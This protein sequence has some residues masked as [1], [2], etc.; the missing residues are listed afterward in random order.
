MLKNLYPQKIQKSLGSALVKY[1]N[2][3]GCAFGILIGLS[4]ATPLF[5]LQLDWN[6]QFWFDQT[7]LNN[8]QLDRNVYSDHNDPTLSSNGSQYI[9]GVG[10]RNIVWYAAFLILKPKII[11]NDSIR[12][13][14]EWH[15]GSPTTGFF[16]RSFPSNGSERYTLM[17]SARDN[18]TIGAQRFWASLITD[19]GTIDLGRAPLHWGLGAIWNS[20]D[21][22]FNRYQSTGD[23]IRLTSKFGNFI[24]APMLMKIAS[25]NNAGGASNN[26]G[27]PIAGNDDVTDYG[28]S[29]KYDNSEEDFELGAYWNRRIANAAQSSLYASPANQ[30][31]GSARFDYNMIDFFVRKKLGHYTFGLEIPYVSGKIGSLDGAGDFDYKAFAAILETKYT[32]DIWDIYLKAGH[33]PGQPNSSGGNGSTY[34][35]MH[36]HN[37]YDLGLILYQFNLLGMGNNSLNSQTAGAV[38]SPYDATITNANYLMLRPEVKLDK[39]TLKAAFVAAWADK[40]ATSGE[41][42]FNHETRRFYRASSSQSKFMGFETDFGT[43][44]QWDENILLGLD[45]GLFFPGGYYSF[46]NTGASVPTDLSPM[47]ASQLKVG[48][49]F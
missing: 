11:V 22:L 1:R 36:L 13:F 19:F 23:L 2:F 29:V 46:R 32:S 41:N 49:A 42:F 6:G 27:S 44:F 43:Y 35:A 26:A 4:A 48:V 24:I 21:H 18:M 30:N 38:V 25:G 45:F 40:T 8:H 17:G 3:F 14:S 47:F 33:V 20:G 39:W 16:G 15:V 12:I 31:G 37:S 34:R 5:A 10:E 9:P 7:W 28:V